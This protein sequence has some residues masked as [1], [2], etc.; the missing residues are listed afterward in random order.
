[1][2]NVATIFFLSIGLFLLS[3]PAAFACSC[4]ESPTV[5]REFAW[6][7]N[8]AVMKLNS[9]NKGP[10]GY[11]VSSVLSIEKVFKGNLKA[12]A[13][14][15]LAQGS[16]ADCIWTFNEDQI[17][18]DF[19]F[20]LADETAIASTCSRSNEI[21]RAAADIKYLE[22]IGEVRRRTRISGMVRK[23]DRAV[24]EG[25]EGRLVALDEHPI[26]IIGAGR[27]LRIKTDENGVYEVYGLPPGQ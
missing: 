23:Y 5:D 4:A 9:V 17:G 13:E 24:L 14:H 2:R 3:A 27:D 10:T 11:I 19:L 6:A 25:Q 7:K 20:Y 22:K 21:S 26:R 8:V 1:M 16:G 15:F 18:Q 12:G